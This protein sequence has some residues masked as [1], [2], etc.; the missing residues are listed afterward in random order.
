MPV[1]NEKDLNDQLRG[2]WLKAMSAIE[3][4][5]LGYAIELLQNLLRQEP[6]FLTARQVLRSLP[7]RA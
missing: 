3:L 1:K 4:Q 7:G 5:N 2:F 6:E